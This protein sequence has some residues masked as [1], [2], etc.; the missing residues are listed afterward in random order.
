MLKYFRLHRLFIKQY[1][2]RL[3]EYKG[4]FIAG[5]LG[6][7]LTQGLTILFISIIFKQIPDINGWTFQ[8]IAFIYG[9]SLIPKGIDHLLFDNLWSVGQRL[10]RKG[11]FDRYLIRPIDPLFHVMIETFEVDAFGEFFTGVALL[12]VSCT[13]IN[14]TIWKI[15]LFIL[16]IPFATLIYTSLKII[17]ASLAFW[18][19]QSGA[20]MYIFYMFNDFSK[21]PITIFNRPIRFTISYIIPFAF[22]AFYPASYFLKNQNIIFN[23]G[24]LIFISI[25]MFFLSKV[26]W[27]KGLSIY[28]SPGS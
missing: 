14:W 22:T 5:M 20:I 3:L 1:L 12:T 26:L 23:L 10:V 15:I 6:V 18:M 17:T 11:D 19:K 27:R 24:G 7:F 8:E 4:D 28:E 9:F 2:K 13:A 21:Y 25:I 16:S